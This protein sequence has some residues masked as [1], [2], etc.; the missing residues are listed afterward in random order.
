MHGVRLVHDIP[1][2]DRAAQGAHLV[3]DVPVDPFLEERRPVPQPPHVVGHSPPARPQQGVP[4][5]GHSR[6]TH[7]VESGQGD[8]S[9]VL[10]VLPRRPL[11]V[12]AEGAVVERGPQHLLVLG[13]GA[14]GGGVDR[15]TEPERMRTHGHLHLGPADRSVRRVTHANLEV[16]LAV[17][18]DAVP[19]LGA[20]GGVLAP[21][22]VRREWEAR[23]VAR[24]EVA[25]REARDL[26]RL[27]SV[28]QPER[29]LG[30]SRR[31][32][33]R[34][35]EGVHV[36]PPPRSELQRDRHRLAVVAAGLL[37]I[38]PGVG[39][40]PSQRPAPEPH[41]GGVAVRQRSGRPGGHPDLAFAVGVRA[42]GRRGD[43][44]LNCPLQSRSVG[45]RA[46]PD[47]N[48][49]GPADAAGP[50]GVGE[51]AKR[52]RAEHV[53]GR[54]GCRA[55]RTCGACRDCLWCCGSS[56][57]WRGDLGQ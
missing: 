20:P 32:A 19:C 22:F 25:E 18:V 11:E 46:R 42:D 23:R 28:T 26:Q 29:R 15:R 31:V 12:V 7:P 2:I 41:H 17:G 24:A 39:V 36:L 44:E 57:W 13:V 14:E 37:D 45:N 48:D 54:C 10:R 49:P 34:D 38:E 43:D 5:G 3:A 27:R 56:R 4:G 30:T 6:R 1:D 9:A 40:G 47:W 35:P 55:R 53:A 21:S 33:A 8:L 50:R 52:I 51:R 16:A